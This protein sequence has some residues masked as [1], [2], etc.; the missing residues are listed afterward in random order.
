MRTRLRTQLKRGLRSLVGNLPAVT[1]PGRRVVVLCYHSIHPTLPFASATPDQFDRQLAWLTATCELVRFEDVPGLAT[2][3]RAKRPAVA[4]TFDDGYADNVDYALPLLK[5][6][7]VPAHF[8]VTTGFADDR[9]AVRARFAQLRKL[10][11]AQVRPLGWSGIDELRSAGMGI[12]SHTVSHPN[13]ARMDEASALAELRSSRERL[14]RHLG[15]PVRTIAYPFGKPGRH[16][17][18]TTERQAAA[19][20]YDLGAAVA[21]RGVRAADRLLC[22]PRF[23]VTRDEPLALQAKVEGRLD[24]V[25]HWQE[26]GP[27]WSARLLSPEDFAVR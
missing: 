26:R 15:E 24:L 12:G 13:L 14:E 5:G 1:G 20:G 21:S 4:I 8:F 7:G 9:P 19:A 18:L 27:R 23:F 25:G 11:L 10:G 2:G 16:L 22:L 17:T 6:H 3:P